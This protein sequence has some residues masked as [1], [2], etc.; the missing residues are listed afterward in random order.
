MFIDNS[1][2]VNGHTVIVANDTTY[3]LSITTVSIQ[4]RHAQ[5][6]SQNCPQ[7]HHGGTQWSRVI[8]PVILNFGTRWRYVVSFMSPVAY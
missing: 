1:T 8:A 3:S 2:C 7:T 6:Q 4:L 5:S